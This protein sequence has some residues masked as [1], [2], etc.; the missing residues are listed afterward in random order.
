MTNNNGCDS[1][2]TFNLTII[3][4][5]TNSSIVM[6]CDSYTWPL[7]GVTYTSSVIDTVIGV[8]ALGCVETNILDLTIIKKK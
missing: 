7:N 5:D 3:N 1:V 2:H 4:S 8:N 6:A